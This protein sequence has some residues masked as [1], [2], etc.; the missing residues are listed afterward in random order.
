MAIWIPWA[1]VLVPGDYLS[2]IEI[3][4]IAG[5]AAIEAYLATLQRL[6]PLVKR[7]EHVVPGHG[8]VIDGARALAVLEE[9]AAYLQAL[10]ESGREARPPA[11][12]RSGAQRELHA[13]NAAAL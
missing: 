12:R 1:E 13:A 7:A 3:P 5:G 4:T 2:S 11:G 8:P 10:R 9:D 6:R